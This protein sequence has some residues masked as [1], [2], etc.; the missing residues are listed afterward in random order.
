MGVK[1][2][3]GEVGKEI[4]FLFLNNHFA[5]CCCLDFFDVSDTAAMG[6][7]QRSDAAP[8]AQPSFGF[9]GPS[10]AVDEQVAVIT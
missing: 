2:G 5:A 4:G 1:R 8:I 9:G 6:E 7:K 10:R 3:D